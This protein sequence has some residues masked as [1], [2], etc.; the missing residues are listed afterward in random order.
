MG[1]VTPVGRERSPEPGAQR[2]VREELTPLHSDSTVQ[3]GVLHAAG[4]DI[5]LLGRHF[6]H[7]Q[8]LEGPVPVM[9]QVGGHDARCLL[10]SIQEPADLNVARVEIG[11]VADKQ[12]G[13]LQG[14]LLGGG[15]A[16]FRLDWEREK[17]LV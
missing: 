7:H 17:N 3:A 2:V 15:H 10:L 5:P 8:D 12:V 4:V 13:V 14:P 6:Q 1:G 16:H 11:H 9:D